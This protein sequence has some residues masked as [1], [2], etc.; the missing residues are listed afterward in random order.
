MKINYKRL[1]PCLQQEDLSPKTIFGR[2]IPDV[3]VVEYNGTFQKLTAQLQQADMSL[4]IDKSDDLYSKVLQSADKI[5]CMSSKTNEKLRKDLII[6]KNN[7]KSY[8]LE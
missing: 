1:Y 2:D 7:E 5:E 4:R 3:P 6:V 8:Q